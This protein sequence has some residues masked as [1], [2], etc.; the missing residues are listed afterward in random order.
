[1]DGTRGRIQVSLDGGLE[2]VW[3]GDGRSLYYRGT[4]PPKLIQAHLELGAAARVTAREEL[5]DLG[6]YVGAEPHAN[7]DV[8]ADGRIVMV[9]RTQLPKLVLLQNVDQMVAAG[10]AR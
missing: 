9:R 7:F 8:A 6:D 3:S 10:A 4:N 5:F 2:P 1:M